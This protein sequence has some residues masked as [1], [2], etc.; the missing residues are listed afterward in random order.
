LIRF[1]VDIKIYKKHSL[2]ASH[3]T[4][5]FNK[6]EDTEVNMKEKGEGDQ[7]ERHGRVGK[8]DASSVLRILILHFIWLLEPDTQLMTQLATDEE[9]VTREVNT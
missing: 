4:E 6:G 7:V 3:R 8:I 9:L 2:V 1:K 5:K